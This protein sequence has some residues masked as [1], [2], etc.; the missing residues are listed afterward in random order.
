MQC[1][2]VKK[3]SHPLCENSAPFAFCC[4]PQYCQQ[5]MCIMKI[6]D[7]AVL[8]GWSK[9]IYIESFHFHSQGRKHGSHKGFISTAVDFDFLYCTAHKEGVALPRTRR[10][11]KCKFW[12]LNKMLIGS[13]RIFGNQFS[14][15]CISQG[16]STRDIPDF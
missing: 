4:V 9:Q 10:E 7:T 8:M 12:I 16:H 1:F 3:R 11:G 6:K 5:N 15:G 13:D 14:L 2:R